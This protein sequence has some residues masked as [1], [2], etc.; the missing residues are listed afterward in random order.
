MRDVGAPTA[1][2]ARARPR[3]CRERDGAEPRESDAFAC[4][5]RVNFDEAT[6]DLAGSPQWHVRCHEV[7]ARAA[8][9]L[10]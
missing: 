6:A 5:A 2:G 4:T 3:H 10:P 8:L 7:G 9:D 1:P